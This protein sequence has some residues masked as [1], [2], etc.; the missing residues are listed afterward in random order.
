VTRIERAARAVVIVI[1]LAAA[2]TACVEAPSSA[3]TA[4]PAPGRVGAE[5]ARERIEREVRAY[6]VRIRSIRCDSGMTGTGFLV[7]RR[8]IVTNRHVIEES[9]RVEVT[10]WDGDSLPVA[11]AETGPADGPDLGII[12]LAA[13]FT[14]ATPPKLAAKN[15]KVN[16]KLYIVGYPEGRA[17]RG[18]TGVVTRYTKPGE[19]ALTWDAGEMSGNVFPGNSGSPVVDGQGRVVGVAFALE[20]RNGWVGMVPVKALHALLDGGTRVPVTPTC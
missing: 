19:L 16:T 12:H 18:T 4:L 3:P 7:D 2:T 11:S 5:P 13:D 20:L 6:T 9:R 1:G 17:P 8:T 15:A 14:A 10:T